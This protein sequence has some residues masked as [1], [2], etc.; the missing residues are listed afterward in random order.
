M[1]A[2]TRCSSE[3]LLRLTVTAACDPR[4]GPRWPEPRRSVRQALAAG[5]L[6]LGS[7]C[8]PSPPAVYSPLAAPTVPLHSPASRLRT[9]LTGSAET[10]D[11]SGGDSAVP[12]R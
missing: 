1:P 12:E 5:A 10:V 8:L 4:S 6:Q 3:M 11:G 9:N 7:D 2:L